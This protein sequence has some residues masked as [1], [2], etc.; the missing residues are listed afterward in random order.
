MD[1]DENYESPSTTSSFLPVGLGV[2][3]MG[4]A[5]VALVIA[6]T[7]KKNS[8]S[9]EDTVAPMKEAVSAFEKRLAALEA[10]NDELSDQNQFLKASITTLV[11]QTQSALNQVGKEITTNREQMAVNAQSLQKLAS[12]VGRPGAAPTTTAKA[13][14]A[15]TA[16][17]SNTSNKSPASTNTAATKKYHVVQP[18]DTLARIARQ[19]NVALATLVR[20]NPQ[21]DPR[22]LSVGQKITI[23]QTNVS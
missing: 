22:K 17:A 13:S 18:G 23:P 14:A 4:L 16:T 21:V 3:A 11:E 15:R 9:P 10:Q 7:A 1:T 20:S 5:L 19:Y 8:F 12:A 2:A 6:W